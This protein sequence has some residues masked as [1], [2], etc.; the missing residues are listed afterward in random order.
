VSYFGGADQASKNKEK[1]GQQALDLSSAQAT[2]TGLQ[3]PNTKPG[4]QV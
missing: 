3:P 2:Q 4:R 1:E